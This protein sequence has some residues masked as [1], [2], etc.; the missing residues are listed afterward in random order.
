MKRE[1]KKLQKEFDAAIKKIVDFDALIALEQEYFGRKNGQFTNL[2]KGMKDLTG[3]RKKEIGQLA[4][5]IKLNS[6]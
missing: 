5:E 1:L 3:K 6:R 4:N 2:V